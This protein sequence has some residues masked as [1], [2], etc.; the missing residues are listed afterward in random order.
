M[1]SPAV[2]PF[3]KILVLDSTAQNRTTVALWQNGQLEKISQ[4]VRAQE[5][6]VLI[7]KLLQK[8]QM[9]YEDFDAFAVLTGPGSYTGTRI[10]VTSA[11][12]LGWLHHKPVIELK[13]EDWEEA[14]AQLPTVAQG[15]TAITQV[16]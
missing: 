12:T 8:L 11:N 10:G 2:S 9:T 5:L 4:E 1:S 13:G 6:Q 15:Q 7:E 14:L 3:Q 16:I